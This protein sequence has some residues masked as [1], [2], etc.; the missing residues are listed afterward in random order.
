MLRRFSANK[1][2]FRPIDFTAGLNV[3]LAEQAPEATRQHSRNARGKTAL[4]QA[5]NFCL[6][7]NPSS[8]LRPLASEGW[9]F[10]LE[11]DMCGANISVTRELAR[12]GKVAISCDGVLPRQIAPYLDEEGKVAV[13]DWKQVLGEQLFG[14]LDAG[15][16]KGPR[17]LSVRTLLSYVVRVDITSSP[18]K[19]ISV[20]PGW[21]S[22]EHV[23]YLLGLDW[24][25]T[26]DATLIDTEIKA[27]DAIDYATQEGLIGGTHQESQLRI[28]RQQ[29]QEE[30]DSVTARINGFQVLDDR[31]GVIEQSD[32]LTEKLRE[33]RNQE[34]IDRRMIALY[35]ESLEV[36][37]TERE[38]AQDLQSLYESLQLTFSP[39]A[40]RRF[41]D[42]A[43]FHEKLMSNRRSFL[44]SEIDRLTRQRTENAQEISDVESRRAS[45]M[46]VL[47][48]GG[49]LEELAA[50][51]NSAIQ[52]AKRVE[53]AD[54]SLR[55]FKEVSEAR[56]NAK[57]RRAQM[58]QAAVTEANSAEETL[59]NASRVL[60]KF[61]MQLYNRRG[62][63]ATKVDDYGIA[64]TLDIEGPK[65]KGTA[66]MQVLA[67]DFS[68][69]S[70][71]SQE[72][73]HPGFLIYDS[74]MFDGVD[75]RQV[76]SA[77]ELAGEI[78]REE[79]TQYICTLNSSEVT[80]ETLAE[81]WFVSA[82]RRNV[83]DTE[84]G[85]IFGCKF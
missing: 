49:A 5:I 78:C 42:V 37:E 79:S 8:Q 62:V 13:E 63:V 4:I 38:D 29:A 47:R 75:P 26:R 51:Q 61:M 3:I 58:R 54:A 84:V 35:E 69:M 1:T 22:R 30:L 43:A 40:V 14:L 71:G 7:A 23:S 48:A 39:D 70:T 34:V 56:E 81:N 28:E 85:G 52:A 65:S 18:F 19:T 77:L 11:L 16:G 46:A 44:Q 64:F 15:E 59:D 60:S 9:A 57:L 55:R 32:R 27:Y 17:S 12:P 21:S 66:K 67:F 41:S 45:V 80:A 73:R 83:L 68:L 33:L 53:A 76:S 25:V 6:A 2:T 36:R 72:G 74:A 50:L 31:E 20:Q 24:K 82:I 10:T